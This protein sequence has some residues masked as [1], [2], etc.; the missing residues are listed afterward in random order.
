MY[1]HVYIYIHI[2]VDI[3]VYVYIYIYTLHN[4]DRG[5]GRFGGIHLIPCRV[6]PAKAQGTRSRKECLP[7]RV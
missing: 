2:F 7:F 5:Q 6:H 4:V 1:I 3:Y